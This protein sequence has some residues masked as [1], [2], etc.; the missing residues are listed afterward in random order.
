[1][2]W[3]GDDKF[4]KDNERNLISCQCRDARSVQ[5]S[6]ADFR[7][8]TVCLNHHR[9][10]DYLHILIVPADESLDT[11]IQ[12]EIQDMARRVDALEM[13]GKILNRTF[14]VRIPNFSCLVCCLHY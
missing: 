7:A 13:H 12:Y 8:P 3:I 1:M 2:H 5:I 4:R 11:M 6:Q 9:D 14:P 10:Y